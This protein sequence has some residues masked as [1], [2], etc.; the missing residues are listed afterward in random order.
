M[1]NIS[2]VLDKLEGEKIKEQISLSAI[3]ERAERLM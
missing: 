2:E 1:I 3:I